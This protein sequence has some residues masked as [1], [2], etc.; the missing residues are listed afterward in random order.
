M[1][2]FDRFFLRVTNKLDLLKNVA[3]VKITTSKFQRNLILLLIKLCF[4]CA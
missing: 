1:P 4:L 2:K 3:C